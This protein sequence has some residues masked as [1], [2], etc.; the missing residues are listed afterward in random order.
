VQAPAKINLGLHVLRRRNDG[1]HDLDTV[2][3]AIPWHDT[4][5]VDEASGIAFSAS[6]P[7]LPTDDRNLVVK[8]ARAL[9]RHLGIEPQAAVHLDKH[10][11]FGAGLGG[12]SSDAAA[13]LRA[14]VQLW[15]AK[16]S[17]A[18]LH[19][20]AAAL[21]SDV[22][23]F[24]DPRPMHATGRGETLVPL[25]SNGSAYT[26]PYPLVVVVPR[27]HVSTVEAYRL[28]QPNDAH[29]ADLAAVVVS[30]DLDRWHRELVNDFEAPV[31]AAFPELGAVRAALV[32]AGAAY[33]SMSGSGSA[34]FGV[35]E[36][37]AQAAS[38][39]ETMR[40]ANHRVWHGLASSSPP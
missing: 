12:G 2:F 25:V 5:T 23:F 7:T 21:G 28:I 27:V 32:D 20:L 36:S 39:A 17:D 22:P 3:L 38:A 1:Y 34:F 14:L 9:A 8:A 31:V 40:H 18:D 33:V 15:E 24:L 19:A 16:V 11:P 6:E 30:N 29:R 10:I 26:L 4:L 35:F 37:T 13:A